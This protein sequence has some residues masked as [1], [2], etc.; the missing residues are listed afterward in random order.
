MRR[1]LKAA[2]TDSSKLKQIAVT[3]VH[4][5]IHH[6]NY[7]RDMT[8][9]CTYLYCTLMM[10]VVYDTHYP[11]GN[12]SLQLGPP[13]WSTITWSLEIDFTGAFARGLLDLALKYVF[14]LRVNS[15]W[16]TMNRLAKEQKMQ[17]CLPWEAD[18]LVESGH[19]KELDKIL[20]LLLGTWYIEESLKGLKRP[21]LKIRSF[22]KSW[23]PPL[24]HDMQ[25]CRM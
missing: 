6:R 10:L 12:G 24:N 5:M 13:H 16:L 18:R 7:W 8:V 25:C 19:F 9:I 4:P 17:K 11:Q 2:S 21:M 23:A 3:I 14:W 22:R 1:E 20:E 15:V